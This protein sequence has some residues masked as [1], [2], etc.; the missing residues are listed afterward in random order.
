MGSTKLWLPSRKSVE[1][2]RG[3][4]SMVLLGHCRFSSLRGANFLYFF[5][6]S[7]S[8]FPKLL[9]FLVS[10]VRGATSHSHRHDDGWW[11]N[12]FSVNG[13]IALSG[14]WTVILESSL[15]FSNVT[16]NSRERV[17]SVYYVGVC[18]LS[19]AK[20]RLIA[21]SRLRWFLPNCGAKR[22]ARSAR[23]LGGV[24]LAKYGRNLSPKTRVFRFIN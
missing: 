2:H 11:G 20:N 1:S 23:S 3:G 13:T 7:L 24:K 22:K 12:S 10:R 8:L 5:E 18:E 4:L 16:K 17:F 6:G 19:H 15:T 21:P 9:M 14:L